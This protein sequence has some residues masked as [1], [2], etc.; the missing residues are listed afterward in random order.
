MLTIKKASQDTW[1]A[2][3]WYLERKDF[4]KWGRKEK[5]EHSG[6]KKNPILVDVKIEIKKLSDEE[7]IKIVNGETVTTPKKSL[8]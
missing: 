6:D 7:L 2:A 4:E 3:A 1:Q 8:E 5:V